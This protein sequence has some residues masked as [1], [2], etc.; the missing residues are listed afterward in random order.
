MQLSIVYS[1]PKLL[2]RKIRNFDAAP[3]SIVPIQNWEA[4]HRY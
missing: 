4:R 3:A 2:R 1:K